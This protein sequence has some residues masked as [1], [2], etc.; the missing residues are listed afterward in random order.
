[1]NDGG[2]T[3]QS[4]GLKGCLTA[5]MGVTVLAI[6]SPIVVAVRGWRA[7]RR[8]SDIRS[9]LETDWSVTTEGARL[10][11]LDLSVDVP[12]PAEPSFRRRLTDSVVRIA[13]EIRRPDDVYHLVYR[14]PWNEEPSAIPVGPQV[15]E[16]GERFSLVQAQGAMAGRTAV[17]LALGRDRA[18]SEVVDPI[19]YDPEVDGEPEGLMAHP[20]NRWSMAT[21][22]V[23]TGS[24]LVTR[25]VVIVPAEAATRVEAVLEELA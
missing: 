9:T 15:Q 19:A 20:D 6:L 3:E 25:V 21:A 12:I 10:R 17:W 1:M 22:W 23:R 7:W 18:L 16:L 4:A 5:G 24:S 13:E 14:L 2:G 11:R 8:G